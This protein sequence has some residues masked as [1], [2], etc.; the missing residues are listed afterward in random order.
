MPVQA[1]SVPA[2]DHA[3]PRCRAVFSAHRGR[4]PLDGGRL[5]IAIDDPLV[6]TWFAGRYLIEELVGQGV[7]GRVYRAR[8]L[9]TRGGVAVL[10]LSGDRAADPGARARFIR[11]SEQVGHDLAG[12]GH[13]YLAVDDLE[14]VDQ[15]LACE[16]VRQLGRLVA[17]PPTA[18]RRRGVVRVAIAAALLLGSAGAG[19]AVFAERGSDEDRPAAK[20]PPSRPEP[21]PVRVVPS[22]RRIP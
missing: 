10:V 6:G 3:C 16:S 4:C 17:S 14:Q 8:H 1:V 12:A 21:P 13:P 22:S 2:F 9:R 20:R 15:M 11:D 5:R 19:F 7:L 18:R